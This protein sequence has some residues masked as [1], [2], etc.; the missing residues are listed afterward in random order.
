MHSYAGIAR[1]FRFM[2]LHV[3]KQLEH[4]RKLLGDAD[5]RWIRPIRSGEGYIDTQKSMIE[6]ECF[7]FIRTTPNQDEQTIASV[8]AVNVITAN[9][10]RIADFV[11]NIA[12]QM[13]HFTE[14]AAARWFDGPAFVTKVLAGLDL[15][16]PALFERDSDLAMKICAVEDDLDR[17]YQAQLKRIIEALRASQSV[18][19]LITSLFIVHYLERMGDALLNVGE[20]ILFAVLGEPLKM[21][22]FRVINQA[23]AAGDA[24]AAPLAEAEVDSIWGTRSGVRIGSV[25]SDEVEGGRRVL[26]KEG[27]PDKLARENAALQRWEQV[28]PGLVPRVVRYQSEGEGAALLLQYLDGQT[29]Q[30]IVLNNDWPFVRRV[31]ARL[32]VVLREAWTRTRNPQP[33]SG[34]YLQQLTDRIEDVYRLHPEFR[35][36]AVQVNTLRSPALVER[37]AEVASLDVELPAPFSVFIHGDFNLDN[38][39][40]NVERDSVHFVDVQRSR[41]MDYVQDVSVFLVS[42]FRL[43]V[44]SRRARRSLEQLALAFLH[45]ARQFAAENED[46]TFEARLALGLIR[47]FVTSTRFELNRR[48]AGGMYQRATLLLGK[49]AKHRGQPWS[50]FRVPD[51]VLIY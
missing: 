2:L 6:N 35:G 44:T 27:S 15:I 25:Q 16:E 32:E 7:A 45:F 36:D 14:P 41:D 33:V 26:F 50:D 39:L 28:A 1:N 29:L 10:E 31:L 49:L 4:T 21:H 37:L 11:V 9:L 22:Q 13:E 3:R 34:G 42:S 38:I 47:S 12:R 46:A 19:N 20:A 30:E 24:S 40:Y 23:L 5:L 51:S 43:P 18:E 48:F 8:R 17:L